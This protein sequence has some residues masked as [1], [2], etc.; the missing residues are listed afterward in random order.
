[1]AGPRKAKPSGAADT[2]SGEL[3]VDVPP[4]SP[5]ASPAGGGAAA[6]DESVPLGAFAERSYLEYAMS[7]VMGRALPDI[8]D[9]QK[10]VQRRI[11]YAMHQLGLYAPA[12]HVKS[13]R[14][15]GDVLG[16]YHPH[17]D[18]AAYDALVRQAQNFTL[19]YPLIDG[20]GNFGS[21]DGDNAAA[22]RYTECRLTAIAQVLLD[23]IDRDT[24]DFAPNYDGAFQEPKLL[25]ARLPMLLLNGSSGIGVGMATDIPSHN[26]G[27]V[28]RAAVAAIRRPQITT[29]ELLAHIPG[30]DLPG[31]GHIISPAADLRAIYEGGRGSL[32]MRAR[33]TVEELAR[34][35][36]RVAIT[37]LPFGVSTRTVL[38][39]IERATN[40]KPREGKKS[41]TQDQ[42][43]LK[44]LMLGALDAVRDESD[45]DA[46]VHLVALGR[47][48]RP[49]QKNL[50]AILDEWIAFRFDTVTRRTRHRLGEV[51]RRIHILEGRMLALLSI[52]RVIRIIRN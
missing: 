33:W 11:L 43:N 25:P 18:T 9:G 3:F 21:R 15:V 2:R 1:M 4:G 12:R 32:R 42:V 10:P 38:E 48:G 39:D 27:E 44:A 30:P 7:V 13:A 47:D 16:K 34:G 22:M 41:L 24:V 49:R 5:P 51:D 37:E 50:K 6:D 31:G 52:D 36:W 23:E 40:P 35:Q 26:L 17:G 45:K 46:P 8:T 29:D 14:V 28:A 20:Q 19:R